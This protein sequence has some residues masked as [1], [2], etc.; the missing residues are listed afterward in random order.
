MNFVKSISPRIRNILVVMS[1]IVVACVI[2]L[3]V[4]N[5]DQQ[6]GESHGEEKMSKKQVYLYYY[7]LSAF[8][9][10]G[11][12]LWMDRAGNL[13]VQKIEEN[14][15]NL[16]V[17][18]R[19]IF[20]LDPANLVQVIETLDAIDWDMVKVVDRSGIP[21]EVRNSFGHRDKNGKYHNF[22]VW[23]EDWGK[24][25]R[26]IQKIRGIITMLL[27]LSLG[28]EV[29]EETPVDSGSDIEFWP[30]DFESL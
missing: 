14:S 4:L 13:V 15:N 30:A 24:Q 5:S 17:D 28:V 23:G 11:E 7:N 29:S 26:E 20:K 8:H 21:D 22:E 9:R 6:T 25:G 19:R 2:G 18:A 3:E 12:A 27:S 16:T 10:D 1:I